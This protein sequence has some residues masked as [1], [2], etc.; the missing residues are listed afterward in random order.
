VKKEAEEEETSEEEIPEEIKLEV[1][2]PP[3]KPLVNK[4]QTLLMIIIKLL[5]QCPPLNRITLG[6]HKSDNN[7]RMIQLTNIFCVLLRY[8]GT[9]NI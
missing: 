3:P 7:N 4:H 2:D 6:Q 5:L 1:E 8:N 9:S